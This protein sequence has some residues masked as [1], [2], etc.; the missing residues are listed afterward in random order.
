LRGVDGRDVERLARV[1][2]EAID[3]QRRGSILTLQRLVADEDGQEARDR[4]RAVRAGTRGLL[5]VDVERLVDARQRVVSDG[6][7]DVQTDRARARG[8]PKESYVHAGA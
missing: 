6:I 5:G 8:A 2:R 1:G 7:R 4:G 3:D